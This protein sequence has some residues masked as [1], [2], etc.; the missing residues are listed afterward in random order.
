MR[1]YCRNCIKSKRECAG[2]V[3]PLVYKQQQ[4]LSN[5]DT[6]IRTTPFSDGDFQFNENYGVVGQSQNTHLGPFN[7][8]QPFAQ[9]RPVTRYHDLHQHHQYPVPATAAPFGAAFSSETFRRHSFQDHNSH[10]LGLHG[11][12]MPM[13]TAHPQNGW[14]L[15]PHGPPADSLPTA[16]VHNGMSWSSVAMASPAFSESYADTSS[17]YFGNDATPLHGWYTPLETIETS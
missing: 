7:P 10:L 12:G 13:Y 17:N 14:A 3:Q 1:K 8:F 6:S 11:T 15:G 2:Y 5:H 9:M 4:G 16:G